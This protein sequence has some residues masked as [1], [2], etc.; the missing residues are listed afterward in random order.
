[1]TSDDLNFRIER[2]QRMV[3]FENLNRSVQ[4][5][6]QVPIG[7]ARACKISETHWN[8]RARAFSLVKKKKILDL[9]VF[10]RIGKTMEKVTV[11][12]KYHCEHQRNIFIKFTYLMASKLLYL[13][14]D[15]ETFS[16]LSA[17]EQVKDVIK[18]L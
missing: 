6:H 5:A 1:M 7:R 10:S 11:N 16:P 3:I 18:A 8:F 9:Q 17:L 14:M 13:L 2:P 4:N 15:W 12:C